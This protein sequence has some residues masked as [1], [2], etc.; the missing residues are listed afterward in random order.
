MLFDLPIYKSDVIF[1]CSPIKLIRTDLIG[2]TYEKMKSPLLYAGE[3]KV[4]ISG[5]NSYIVLATFLLAKYC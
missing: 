2:S 1:E 5:T 4:F 3:I